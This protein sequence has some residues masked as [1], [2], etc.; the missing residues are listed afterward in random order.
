MYFGKE[1]AL[2]DAE[3]NNFKLHLGIFRVDLSTISYNTSVQQFA[4]REFPRLMIAIVNVMRVQRIGDIVIPLKLNMGQPS[5][6]FTLTENK[7][8]SGYK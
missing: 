8:N 7:T 4:H 2:D 5:R 3:Q 6:D 1:F